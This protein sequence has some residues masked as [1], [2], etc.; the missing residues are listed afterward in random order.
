MDN[1]LSDGT[2]VGHIGIAHLMII[3]CN[4]APRRVA[5][6]GGQFFET[7]NLRGLLDK[8]FLESIVLVDITTV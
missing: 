6:R 7:T 3:A 8:V 2:G 1:C 5:G 4:G